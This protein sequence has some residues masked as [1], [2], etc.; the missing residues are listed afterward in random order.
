MVLIRLKGPGSVKC[1]I[2]ISKTKKE[3]HLDKVLK[4][5]FV[6][7][8]IFSTL[9]SIPMSN[10]DTSKHVKISGLNTISNTFPGMD[11]VFKV[12]NFVPILAG[13]ISS[14][15][16]NMT[17]KHS[18]RFQD[19]CPQ[20]NIEVELELVFSDKTSKRIVQQF[21]CRRSQ[22]SFLFTFMDDDGSVQHAATIKPLKSCLTEKCPVF[23]TNHG[24]GKVIVMQ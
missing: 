6:D 10:L 24:T 16:I 9:I 17:N 8:N 3:F 4:P 20:S 13:Q 5:D 11:P 1:S 22:Q 19:R 15:I 7:G 14:I 12:L 21:R 2:R 18:Q 23:L